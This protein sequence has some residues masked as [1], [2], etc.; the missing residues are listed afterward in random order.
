MGRWN[1]KTKGI[2]YARQATGQQGRSGPSAQ[3][4]SLL[5]VAAKLIGASVLVAATIIANKF[6]SSMSATNLLSQREQADS[7]LRAGM[8]RDLIGPIAGSNK[9]NEN[10]PADRERLLVELLALNFHEHF[11][12]KPVMLH[13]DDR[14][15]HEKSEEMNQAQKENARESLRS[16]ARRVLQRQLAALTKVEEDSLPEAQACV[17]RLDMN[18]LLPSNSPQATSA[19]P[20]CSRIAGNFGS[21]ISV[22]SPSGMYTLTFVIAKP[23]RWEDQNFSVQMQIANKATN[24][25]RAIAVPYEFLLTWFDFP[26]TDNT[27][28]ADGTRF[29]L[30]IDRVSPQDKTATLKLIWFPQD[31]F[32]ARERP[33]NHHQLREKLGLTLK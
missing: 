9:A 3:W 21:L 18:E 8:F 15:A 17:Y 7:T 29:S 10:I 32:S 11:E 31:Y 23:E 13:V 12:L 2:P 1:R 22:N 30:A 26:F 5:D 27:L 33:T 25:S 16:V 20:P 19:P 6:Q 4:I 24:Q 28:L 14:L